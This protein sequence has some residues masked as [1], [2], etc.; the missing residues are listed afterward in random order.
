MSHALINDGL[1]WLT[2][3]SVVLLVVFVG[4][5]VR[6]PRELASSPAQPAPEPAPARPRPPAA[7]PTPLPR[8]Q[9]GHSG[10]VARHASAGRLPWGR[11]Q[12][13]QTSPA[14]RTGNG[15]AVEFRSGPHSLYAYANR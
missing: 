7:A 13:H 3:L 8:R 1:F 11:R 6:P 12:N 10:Y 14:A 9:P 2:V 15:S 5:A 4:A